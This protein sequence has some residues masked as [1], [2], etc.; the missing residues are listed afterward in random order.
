MLFK[1]IKDCDDCPIK[2]KGVCKGGWTS[3][4]GGNPIEPPCVVCNEDTDIDK[5]ISVCIYSD[6]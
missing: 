4:G 3:D 2:D 1:D 6:Y 5:F